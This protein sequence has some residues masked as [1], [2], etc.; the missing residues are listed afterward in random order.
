MYSYTVSSKID[1]LRPVS[2]TH[3]TDKLKNTASLRSF[4]SKLFV[5]NQQMDSPTL[6]G[7]P[8]IFTRS[9]PALLI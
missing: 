5:G 7:L 1:K 3:H 4:V 9:C 6:L 2:S 8:A